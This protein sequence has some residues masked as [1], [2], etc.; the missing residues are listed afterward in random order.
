MSASAA[1]PAHAANPP[2]TAPP[3][4]PAQA[5]G[6]ARAARAAGWALP[7]AG[8]VVALALWW[9]ATTLLVP[10]QHFL[11]RFAPDKTFAALLR[12]VSTGQLWPHLVTS[13]RRVLV[14]LSISAALGIPLGLAVGS[15]PVF[16]R[17]SGP[18]FQFIRMVSPLSWT[19]LAIILLG[20]G[21]APVYFLI[22][23]AGVWPVVLN[24]SAGVAALD[25]RWLTVGRSLGATRWELLRTIVWPGVRP[26]V[27]TGLRLAVGVAWVILVPAEM[28]GVSSG[29][30]YFV[31][32]TRDRLAYADLTAAIL[33]IGACGFLL[34]SAARWLFRERRRTGRRRAAQALRGARVAPGSAPTV[35]QVGLQHVGRTNIRL[36]QWTQYL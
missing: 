36:R 16:A 1:R 26:N 6:Q 11:A 20:V 12:L 34:D 29:L 3:T 28:L 9:A 8:V 33:V 31:L 7:L 18:I 2:P 30:G 19:P 17:M 24:T 35:D 10:P 4:Q 32:N 25:P 22:A 14:G 23:I 15:L 5:V 27:L 21:D 13:L